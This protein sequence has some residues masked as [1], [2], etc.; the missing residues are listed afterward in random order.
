MRLLLSYIIYM[1]DPLAFIN[2]KHMEMSLCMKLCYINKLTIGI[3][4]TL[5][6][7]NMQLLMCKDECH[8]EPNFPLCSLKP[9]ER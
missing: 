2:V 8:V 7:G 3:S 5:N 6:T 4:V 9:L 1:C